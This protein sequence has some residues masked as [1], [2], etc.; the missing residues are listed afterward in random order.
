MPSSRIKRGLKRTHQNNRKEE[1]NHHDDSSQAL[2]FFINIDHTL[3]TFLS[4]FFTVIYQTT[5]LVKYLDFQK[6]TLT[7]T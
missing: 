3:F 6:K 5:K 7:S 4:N 2:P 1:K